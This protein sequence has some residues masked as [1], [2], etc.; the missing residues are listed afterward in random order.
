MRFSRRKPHWTANNLYSTRG[1]EQL[2]RRPP[3]QQGEYTA[4]DPQPEVMIIVIDEADPH[5]NERNSTSVQYG[6]LYTLRTD[7]VR[8]KDRFW[9]QPQAWDRAQQLW[10]P[11]GQRFIWGV[12]GTARWDVDH[13]LTGFNFGVKQYRIRRGG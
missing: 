12:V 10:V 7:D 9:F 8:D 11:F 13:A 1:V 4:V 2:M 3:D 6:V 5:A